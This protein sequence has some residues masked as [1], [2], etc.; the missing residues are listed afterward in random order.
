MTA[1]LPCCGCSYPALCTSPAAPGHFGSQKPA[2]H[3]LEVYTGVGYLTPVTDHCSLDWWSGE[4]GYRQPVMSK[5]GG[6]LFSGQM[7]SGAESC[8]CTAQR[9]AVGR[10]LLHFSQQFLLH[11]RMLWALMDFLTAQFS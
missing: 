11:T 3:C 4:E 7:C 9:I 2:A 8:I 1:L 10:F 5:Q 6:V